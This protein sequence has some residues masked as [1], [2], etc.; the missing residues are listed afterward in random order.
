[1]VH[2]EKQ[3][4]SSFAQLATLRG[5]KKRFEKLASSFDYKASEVTGYVKKGAV[6]CLFIAYALLSK[7]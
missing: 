3:Y 4:G 6:I 5:K 7:I 2:L 1:M